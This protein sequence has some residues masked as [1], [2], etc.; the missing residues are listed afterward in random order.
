MQRPASTEEEE[1][2]HPVDSRDEPQQ[3]IDEVNPDCT[4]HSL[5]ATVTFSFLVDVHFTE[6]AEESG[7]QYAAFH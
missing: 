2:D 1:P 5:D 6:E 3:H 7:E 4:L